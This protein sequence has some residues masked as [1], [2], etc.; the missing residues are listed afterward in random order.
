M[1]NKLPLV[2]LTLLTMFSC[3]KKDESNPVITS[4]TTTIVNND[5]LFAGSVLNVAVELQD[6]INLGGVSVSIEE[7]TSTYG[8]KNYQHEDKREVL[9]LAGVKFD[10]SFNI[11]IHDSALAAPYKVL[12]EAFDKAGNEADAVTKEVFVY[13]KTMPLI[14]LDSNATMIIDTTRYKP[15]GNIFSSKGVE[16][17]ELTLERNNT[18]INTQSWNYTDNVNYW[19]FDSVAVVDIPKGFNSANLLIKCTDKI[20]NL[21]YE[22]IT[23]EP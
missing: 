6:N 17:I 11:L 8:Y 14:Y 5:S 18:V 21:S 22:R 7:Q 15:S 20:G 23:I 1:T 16:T 3:K 2:F 13:N 12:V 10:G 9:S 19:S 4:V